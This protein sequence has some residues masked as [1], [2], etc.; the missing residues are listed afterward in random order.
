MTV[1][2]IPAE[3]IRIHILLVAKT[4][5]PPLHFPPSYIMMNEE[6][7]DDDNESAVRALDTALTQQALSLKD[8]QVDLLLATSTTTSSVFFIILN[9]LTIG[10]G[11]VEA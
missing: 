8:L 10:N 3:A 2:K 4:H 9:K 5:P 6:R 1:D 11:K 7:D